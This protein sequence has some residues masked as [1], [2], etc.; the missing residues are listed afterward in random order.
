MANMSNVLGLI[1]ANMHE[2]TVTD[3]TKNRAM[4]SIPFGARYRLI[5]FPLSNMVNSGV[6]NVGVVTKSNYQSLIDH[7]GSGDEWDLS[8]KTGG[9]HFLPPYSNNFTNGG[10]YRGRLEA[11]AGVIG[12]ITNAHADYVLLTDCDCVANVDYKKIVDYHEEKGADIT[13]VY[14]R[15]IFTP[16]QTKTR[17]I[18]QVNE[19]GDVCDILIRPD[20]AG[21][22]DAS[23][24]I[25][26]MSKEFLLKIINESMSRNLYSFEVDVL[27]H[28]LSEFKVSG[29][30]FDGYYSQI[31][32]IQA[33]YQA[34][35]DIMNKEVRTE[36]FN[37]TDPIYTKVRDDAPAKYG[38]EASAKN[39]L[40]A[41]G[42]VIEGTVENSVLFRGVKVGKGAV[43]KNCILMQDA[44]V[45]D[46]CELNYVIADK[47]VKVG[48][49]RSLC[50][51]VDYPVFVNKNSAV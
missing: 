22:F 48:N 50:G 5:D 44:E 11:L 41:D 10:L 37:L 39:S 34:N 27:Q 30:R 12:F 40:I 21:E 9:L 4:A 38:L 6:S 35:M 23:M 42:C 1:F 7:I 45:G 49:Y 51:T 43:I 33:Y 31:D 47:N 18:L 36:L 24:N 3:L 8:R 28:R 46:K 19:Q 17:T 13:V 15:S 2:L 14:G 16:E 32:S 20:M 29:Y 26:V 25:F